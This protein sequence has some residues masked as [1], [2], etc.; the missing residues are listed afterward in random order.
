MISGGRL[1]TA[2]PLTMNEEPH[3]ATSAKSKS[4]SFSVRF[5]DIGKYPPLGRIG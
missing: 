2:M 5:V 4:Q 3:I 1:E